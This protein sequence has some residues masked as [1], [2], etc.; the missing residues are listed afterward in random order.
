MYTYLKKKH[1][2]RLFIKCICVTRCL[3][4]NV[5]DFIYADIYDSVQKTPCL[6]SSTFYRHLIINVY[7]YDLCQA[8]LN[9]SYE[10]YI[11]YLPVVFTIEKA[12]Y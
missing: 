5:V 2:E 8:I 12:D 9:V 10:M 6:H 4:Q 1:I 7:V 11:V 3:Y